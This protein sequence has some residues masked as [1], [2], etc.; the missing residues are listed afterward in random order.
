MHIKTAV[1]IV[2]VQKKAAAMCLLYHHQPQKQVQHTV[3]KLHKK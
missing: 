1:P 3:K 2:I